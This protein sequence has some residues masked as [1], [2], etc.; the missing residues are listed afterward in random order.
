MGAHCIK[1]ES[2]QD[3]ETTVAAAVNMAFISNQSIAILLSQ[4]LIGAKAF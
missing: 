1:I 2:E 4:K 3:I